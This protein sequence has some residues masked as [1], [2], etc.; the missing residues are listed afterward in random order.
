MSTASADVTLFDW[1]SGYPYT[2]TAVLGVTA[3]FTILSFITW[4]FDYPLT[5]GSWEFSS[6]HGKTFFCSG[7]AGTIICPILAFSIFSDGHFQ[8]VLWVKSLVGGYIVCSFLGY[9]CARAITKDRSRK[10]R[11]ARSFP[12]E[13]R[14]SVEPMRSAKKISKFASWNDEEEFL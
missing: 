11:R 14:R 6:A 12:A 1:I 5:I 4:D 2:A 13:Q 10:S 3:L 9:F 8:S 7:V